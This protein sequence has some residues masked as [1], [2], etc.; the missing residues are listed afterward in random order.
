MLRDKLSYYL[1]NYTLQNSFEKEIIKLIKNK[2]K[3]VLFD[4]GCYRGVFTKTISNLIGKKKH[5]FYL[6]DI[7]QKVKKY[8]TNKEIYFVL[9]KKLFVILSISN[10]QILKK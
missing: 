1:A 2:S 10:H 6:F 9:E 3:L 8:I 7:N 5:K 4:V